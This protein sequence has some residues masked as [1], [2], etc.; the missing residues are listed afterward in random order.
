MR[1]LFS[2]SDDASTLVE[3]QSAVN[4]AVNYFQAS[5]IL[6]DI[7]P[8][9]L[10]TLWPVGLTKLKCQISIENKIQDI[11]KNIDE[12]KESAQVCFLSFNHGLLLTVL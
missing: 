11:S 5:I 7:G 1:S 3:L 12:L 8:R 6:V 10:L 2:S 4:D 9:T